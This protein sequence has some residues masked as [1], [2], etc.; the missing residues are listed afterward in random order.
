RPPVPPD[1]PA[2]A[3]L[4]QPARLRAHPH[5]PRPAHRRLQGAADRARARRGGP[6]AGHVRD[7]GPCARRAAGVPAPARPGAPR[8]RP[9][10]GRGHRPL[11]DRASLTGPWFH[12]VMPSFRAR[13]V[14]RATLAPVLTLAGALAPAAATGLGVLTWNT[15]AA[16]N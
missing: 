1:Q 13:M 8:Q 9:D 12:A 15:C 11:G 10:H 7:R 4:Q 3:L 6:H 16:T 2:P 5:R 14:V